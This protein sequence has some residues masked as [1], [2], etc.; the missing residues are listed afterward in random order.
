MDTESKK[1]ALPQSAAADLIAACLHHRRGIGIGAAVGLVLAL[2][3]LLLFK[4]YYTA[5]VTIIEG[6]DAQLNSASAGAAGG[7]LSLAGLG[8]NSHV[9]DFDQFIYF[10]TSDEVANALLRSD[11]AVVKRLLVKEWSESS[12]SWHAPSGLGIRR[13]LLRLLS[14]PAWVPPDKGGLAETLAR[15]VQIKIVT[16]KAH[17]E[18]TFRRMS[19]T[20]KDP[21]L[22]ADLLGAIIKES[23]SLVRQRSA[24]RLQHEISNLDSDIAQQGFV[25][26]R[27][28]L[29]T[30]IADRL[31]L[32]SLQS[33][34]ETYPAVILDPIE[35]PQKPSGPDIGLC[36][37][38]ALFA[39]AALGG[40]MSVL[41]GASN[42]VEG[43]RR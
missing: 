34:S 43:V 11:L 5:A 20:L 24:T 15:V 35:V 1:F 19:V 37:V 4:P 42:G 36:L 10:A 32:Q 29:G 18:A 41:V 14:R 26:V 2:T 33:A 21:V 27:T 40:L 28:A 25:E 13:N 31:K 12:Q 6:P 7:L 8:Q 17:P 30:A 23:S 3:F 9:N 38:G 39:G 22:A 16:N